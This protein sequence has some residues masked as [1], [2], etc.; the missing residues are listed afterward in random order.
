MRQKQINIRTEGGRFVRPLLTVHDNEIV[1]R[2]EHLSLSERDWIRLGLVEW[3]DAAEEENLMIAMD[4]SCLSTKMKSEESKFVFQQTFSHCE[5]HPS[6]MFGLCASFIP[7]AN[8]NQATKNTLQ[9]AM[10]K[11]AV[12]TPP[13]NHQ[14][15]FPTISHQLFYPQ[16]PIVGTAL[17]RH[18]LS[19]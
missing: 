13:L 4:A 19:D 15:D 1:M 14:V 18:I 2:K 7:F 11:Q 5:I 8:H 17:S 9:C 6:M 3:V 12:G 16:R 10:T